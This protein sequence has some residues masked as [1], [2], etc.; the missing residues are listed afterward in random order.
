MKRAFVA[1]FSMTASRAASSA[2][3]SVCPS[4]CNAA[5]RASPAISD[6][7]RFAMP[8]TQTESGIDDQVDFFGQQGRDFANDVT[9]QEIHESVAFRCAENQT[10][11]AEGRRNVDD[12]FGGR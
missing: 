7:V 3:V 6:E 11:S 5:K 1:S 2:G 8:R 4:K 9:A 10:R 12:R